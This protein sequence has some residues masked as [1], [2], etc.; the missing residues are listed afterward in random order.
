MVGTINTS[1]MAITMSA[2]VSPRCPRRDCSFS[3]RGYDTTA[4]ASAQARGGRKGRRIAIES[5]AA[6]R[7]QRPRSEAWIF[8]RSEPVSL[9]ARA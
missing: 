5:E 7:V 1:E 4:T 3:K 9:E 2:A 6:I 8:A